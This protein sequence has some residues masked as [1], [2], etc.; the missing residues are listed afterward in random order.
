MILFSINRN[1]NNSDKQMEINWHTFVPTKIYFQLH[2][3]F[4]K[5]NKKVYIPVRVIHIQRHAEKFLPQLIRDFKSHSVIWLFD[6]ILG[7]GTGLGH[8]CILSCVCLHLYN[9]NDT[10]E[11]M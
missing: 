9:N 6:Q 10:S 5:K 3:K 11:K 1:K 4:T 8:F 7:S 2:D